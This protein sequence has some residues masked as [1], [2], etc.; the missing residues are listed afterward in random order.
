MIEEL[1]RFT[2]SYVFGEDPDTETF[3]TSSGGTRWKRDQSLVKLFCAFASI[4][5]QIPYYIPNES[6][7]RSLQ[8]CFSSRGQCTDD[9]AWSGVAM[10]TT[11]IL[12]SEI[13]MILD[14]KST[15]STKYSK[16]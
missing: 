14:R 16:K 7:N 10:P 3:Q 2:K 15:S 12:L 1:S 4:D 9:E 13:R 5:V 6:N 11:Q 8:T